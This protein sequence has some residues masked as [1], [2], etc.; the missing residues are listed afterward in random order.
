M[1]LNP[2]EYL[3][4]AVNAR[5]VYAELFEAA[6]GVLPPSVAE[7][8][9]IECHYTARDLCA[10]LPRTVSVIQNELRWLVAWGWITNRAKSVRFLGRRIDGI[11]YLLSDLAA[12]NVTSEAR[13]VSRRILGL[14]YSAVQPEV[15]EESVQRGTMRQWRGSETSGGGRLELDS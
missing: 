7:P 1:A 8:S 3:A 14:D 9:N 13:L 5:V 15:T 2:E 4:C 6:M 12:R 11:P 10:K